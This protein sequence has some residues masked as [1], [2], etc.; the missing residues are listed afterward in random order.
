MFSIISLNNVSEVSEQLNKLIA[1][2]SVKNALM[3]H[4]ADGKS[5]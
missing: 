3:H 5:F 2:L 1:E 4:L